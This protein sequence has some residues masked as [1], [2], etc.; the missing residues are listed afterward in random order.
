[1]TPKNPASDDDIWREIVGT[2]RDQDP[3]GRYVHVA[4]RLIDDEHMRKRALSVMTEVRTRC[5][6]R[7]GLHAYRFV[8][9]TEIDQ[10][11]FVAGIQHHLD[12]VGVIAVASMRE[13]VPQ[14]SWMG[15]AAWKAAFSRYV[16]VMTRRDDRDPSRPRDRLGYLFDFV[17]R[18]ALAQFSMPARGV[19][20]GNLVHA[21]LMDD[22]A[23]LLALVGAYAAMNYQERFGR[24][25]AYLMEAAKAPPLIAAREEGG[26]HLIHVCLD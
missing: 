4:E 13:L 7:D 6:E 19:L 23:E 15:D 1:M 17:P 12:G 25:A 20:T 3:C 26:F 21:P 11:R 8:R 5:Y 2:E 14:P 24:A 16:D 18:K 10:A 9:R 22:L